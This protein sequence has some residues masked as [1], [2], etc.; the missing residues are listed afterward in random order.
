[1]KT[2]PGM[3]GI[4]KLFWVFV[5]IPHLAIWSINGEKACNE[6]LYVKRYSVHTVSAGN[7]FALNCPVKY[8]TNRPNVSWCKLEE[9]TCQPLDYKRQNWN[10]KGNISVFILHFNPLLPSDTGSYRCSADFPSGHVESHSVTI[11][12]TEWTRNNSEHPVLTL[13]HI[14]DTTSASGPPST[15]VMENKH[16]MLYSLLPLGALPLLITCFYL[17]CC[18][19]RHQEQKKPSDTAG[20]EI[21]VVDVPQLFRNEQTEAGTRQNPQTLPSGTS[22]YDN[23]PWLRVQE[24][25]EVYSN[26]CLEENKQ[27]VVYASLNHSVIGINAREAR[28]VKEAPTE[29]AAICVR[30]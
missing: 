26:P 17:F 20:R 3:L 13:T 15:E 9:K 8:C 27:S 24:E 21:N 23:D 2:S 14:S 7:S 6:Q 19:R 5:L 28:N 22:T 18:L 10:E 25:T 4:G 1:M 29:Y 16:W 12:V 11:N 30:S